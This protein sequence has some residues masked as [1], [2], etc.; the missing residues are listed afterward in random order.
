MK[1]SICIP[2][3]NFSR[4]IGNTI[5]SVRAQQV[6]FEIHVSDN[7]STDDSCVV[8][9]AYGDP[10]ISLSRNN[11]N[12]GFAGNL[13][14][15]CAR[16]TGDRMILLSSDDL[17]GPDALA[18]Y[19][20]IAATLGA[21]HE[22]TVFSATTHVIDGEGVVT[23]QIGMDSKLWRGAHKDDFLS[24]IAGAPVWRIDSA[25]LLANSM[26][27]LRVPFSFATTCYARSLYESVEG[28]GGGRLYNPD[29]HFAWKL[30]TRAK[31]AIHVDALL[32]SY[33]IHGSN[34][35]A[36]QAKTGALKHLVDQYSATFETAPETLTHANLTSA[37]LAAAFIEQDVALRGLA[38]V[39]KGR[40]RDARRTL[41][42]GWAA[43]PDLT[44]RSRKIWA[45]R[46]LLAL[47]PLGTYIAARLYGRAVVRFKQD[48]S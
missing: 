35:D 18:T 38:M 40:R 10:R 20:K 33:R 31:E 29:K 17:I 2:N 45:L 25:L 14:K 48:G 28:Y 13:D 6:D 16:A 42:F 32:F 15:A 47:G 41:D 9:E 23:G 39:A 24:Q 21:A 34:Q 7:A 3:Y 43:Y 30:L 37:E 11:W 36:Q 22:T 4:Y 46:V 26:H 19:S 27:Y 5:D 44:A 12:V 8:I 1:F